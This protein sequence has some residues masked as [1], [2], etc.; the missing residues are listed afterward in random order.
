MKRPSSCNVLDSVLLT[1]I[2]CTRAGAA[3]PKVFQYEA[4][5]KEVLTLNITAP[6]Q[7]DTLYHAFEFLRESLLNARD[8]ETAKDTRKELEEVG[9]AVTAAT[10]ALNRIE[11]LGV[12]EPQRLVQIF[13]YLINRR[14][15]L[16]PRS[17][18]LPNH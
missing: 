15:E 1:E 14:H 18:D 13:R 3:I 2:N 4:F 11:E 9:N 8:A 7:D 12:K 5:A 16:D 6:A 10:G 17:P